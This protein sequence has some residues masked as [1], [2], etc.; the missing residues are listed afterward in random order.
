MHKSLTEGRIGTLLIKFSLPFLLSS[1]IMQAYS[2]VDVFI[3]GHYAATESISGAGNGASLVM[4]VTS[5]FMGLSNGGMIL[6]GQFF[7]AKQ[8][9]KS[10]RT[11]GNIVILQLC[12]VA[13]SMAIVVVLGRGFIRLIKVPEPADAEA[14]NY[15]RICSIGL[16]F[17]AGYGMVSSILRALGNS[18]TPLYFVSAA[19]VMNILLDLLFV[20]KFGWGAS[21]A[22]LATVISQAFSFGIAMVYMQYHSL[23]FRFT[24]EDIRPDKELL[25]S[26]FKLGVPIS[27]QTALNMVSFIWVGG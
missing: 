9:E 1:L 26:M 11:I 8:H 14:W 2:S 23:P 22:A 3:L 27:L 21:G 19:C 15:M 25:R 13:V 16:A 4:T 7:G 18:K 10:A 6:L 5:F 24:I 12:I 17:N 20:G